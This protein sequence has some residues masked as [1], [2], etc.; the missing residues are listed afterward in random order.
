MRYLAVLLV[1][2]AL[3]GAAGAQPAPV[4]DAAQTIVHM[5]DSEILRTAPRSAPDLDR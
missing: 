4:G 3:I 2:A 5:L 1:T